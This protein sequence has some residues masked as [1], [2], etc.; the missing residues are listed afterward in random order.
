MDNTV[1]K[2]NDPAGHPA[3]LP[4]PSR[5]FVETTTHC[6]LACSMCV[7]HAEGSVIGSDHM[8]LDTLARLEPV[9]DNLQT[10]VLNGIG[11]PLMH[12]QLET[13]IRRARSRM[14]AASTISF[15]SNGLLLDERRAVSLAEAG[16]DAICISLDAISPAT[17]RRVRQ[18]AEVA[19]VQGAFE[20]IGRLRRTNRSAPR[21]GVEFVVKQDN[22]DELPEVI[23]WAAQQGASFAIVTQLM[24][25][26]AS[27][28]GQTIYD[29]N[30]DRAV[31]LFDKWRR[32]AA[33]RA[34][35]LEDYRTQAW[36]GD[37]IRDR[38]LLDLVEEMKSEAR[39]EEVFIHLQQ[40]FERNEASIERATRIFGQASAIA[41]RFGLDLSL[42]SVLPRHERKCH[43]VEDGGAFISRDGKVHPCYNL[44]HG[45]SCFINGWEKAVAP[46]V[47]GNVN[48]EPLIDIWRQPAWRQFRSNVLRYD[49]PYCSNC[50]VAPCDFIE[51]D[52][53]EQDCY[54][55]E[56]PCGTCLWAMGLLHCLR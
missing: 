22:L 52:D 31:A 1:R 53:F 11:E 26:D 25:Y 24:P 43:F 28:V 54:I 6:N 5:L 50:S 37:R 13:F 45:Y 21:L 8:G 33:E 38:K 19:A 55:R 46:K 3:D 35:V 7:K 49:Y 4:Y 41:R 36:K 40:L 12:P 30:T 15:Q 42:P 2:F 23:Q 16:L 39:R 18:G 51:K 17:F 44:W 9:F 29:A 56:E 34:L 27:Q 10:L 47:L 48:S 20:A 14:P 32:I